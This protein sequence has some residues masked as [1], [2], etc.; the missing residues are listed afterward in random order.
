M[1][2]PPEIAVPRVTF[3]WRDTDLTSGETQTRQMTSPAVLSSGWQSP[4]RHVGYLL[5]NITDEPQQFD[6][7]VRAEGL[8][9]PYLV[10]AVRDGVYEILSEGDSLPPAMEIAL[11]PRG[12]ALVA[13]VSAG[14][15]EADAARSSSNATSEPRAASTPAPS[16]GSTP[17]CGGALLVFAVAGFLWKE[18][19]GIA[20][21]D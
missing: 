14:S 16:S 3:D 15:E 8:S 18:L 6:L 9:G 12:V 21:R 5:S 1:L 17:V 19:R 10:Y 7:P 13:I 20:V 4:S 11:P 2:R